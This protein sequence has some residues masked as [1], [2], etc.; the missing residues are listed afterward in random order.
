MTND[1]RMRMESGESEELFSKLFSSVPD[2]VIRT[3]MSGEIL[4]VN[5]IVFSLAG[6]H[7]EDLVG[8][9]MFSYIHP[10]DL[11]RAYENTVLMLEKPLGS[12]EYDIIKK[13][14]STL[15]V[16]VNG[17]VLRREGGTPFGIVL[18]CRDITERKRAE[19]ELRQLRNYLTNIIDSMPSV[20]IGVDP[21]GIVTQWNRGAQRLTGLSAEEATGQT[22]AAAI[23]RLADRLESVREAMNTKEVHI[24]P[25]QY[26]H[27]NGELKYEDVTVY[28]LT[29]NGIE[30]AVIRVDDVTEQRHIQEMM[31]QSEKMLSVGGLAAGMAHEINNPLA[32]MMQT[33]HVL[34]SRLFED[35]PANSKA[36]VQAGT[37]IEAIRTFMGMRDVP[38]M[39]QRIRESGSRAAEIVR[40]MLSF[41]RRSESSFSSQSLV[42]LIEQT[43]N[44]ASSDYD[45][46]KKYD[47]RKIG[48]IREF[49][50]NLPQIPCDAGQL[51]QVLLN[52]LRNGAEAMHEDQEENAAI[53]LPQFKIRV[54]LDNARPMVRIEIEDNGPGMDIDTRK[55]VFEP[56]FTTKST[57]RGIGLGL[58]VSYFI[59][60]ETHGGE[61]KVESNP[62]KGTRFIIQLPLI[63]KSSITL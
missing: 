16:E 53:P 3:D 5:D 21:D 44:L 6:Y 13:D 27:D 2:I 7:W 57:S 58:S 56:F 46:E 1:H 62:G 48:I 37:S 31:V 18:V 40:N 14:G 41:A 24:E 33:A 25:N 45:L 39:L 26:Y 60:T 28:P 35:L 4:F 54:A 17:D 51:Q 12:I 52:I 22:L 43:I 61:M 30:G 20:L 47:F 59:I 42:D 34:S 9:N 10:K 36:A 50:E 63:S 49:E 38:G 23:P 11:E 8:K 32:G 55:R 19:Q 29:T 15:T